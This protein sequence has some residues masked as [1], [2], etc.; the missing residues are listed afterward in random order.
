MGHARALVA[1]QDEHVQLRI[2]E[3]I[4]KQGLN[5]RQVEKIVREVGQK[6]ESQSS[7]PRKRGDS[8]VGSIEERMQQ[9]LGTRVRITVQ[10][11]GKGEINVEFYSNDDLER[12]FDLI[13]TIRS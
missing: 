1:L 5:V 7:F 4:V 9:I 13:S 10:D 12:L 2:F 6:S 8:V 11:G 3:R